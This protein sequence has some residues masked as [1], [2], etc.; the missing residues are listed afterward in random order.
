MSA[1]ANKLFADR[2]KAVADSA[3]QTGRMLSG[4]NQN[5][6]ELSKVPGG[7]PQDIVRGHEKQQA[8][9]VDYLTKWQGFTQRWK[10]CLPKSKE[11]A[12]QTAG[13]LQ[14]F[15]SDCLDVVNKVAKDQDRLNA[16]PAL[17]KFIDDMDKQD[18]SVAMSREILDLKRD[19]DALVTKMEQWPPLD[20]DDQGKA[21]MA[22]PSNHAVD[23]VNLLQGIIDGLNQNIKDANAK[24]IE[25][26]TLAGIYLQRV[27]VNV[28]Y[29]QWKA[30]QDLR[31]QR[32]TKITALKEARGALEGKMPNV[33]VELK[34][35]VDGWQSEVDMTLDNLVSLAE[36]WSTVRTRAVQLR[37]ALQGGMDATF[38]MR[39]KLEVSNAKDICDPLRDGLTSYA[40][41][42]GTYLQT[43]T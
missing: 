29:N 7:W 3:A 41:V 37:T 11:L 14:R 21:L 33:E 2:I 16:I 4:M 39:M 27:Q 43:M 38:G 23:R 40:T 25:T 36:I 12:T 26:A 15:D 31:Q 13:V 28:D 6:D 34:L 1:S 24:M 22:T 19:I 30:V 5:L 8:D 9:L 10:Q 42:M 20:P 17:Q 35:R 18:Q 32:N